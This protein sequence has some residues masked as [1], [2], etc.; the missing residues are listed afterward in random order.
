MARVASVVATL[1]TLS[2][3]PL[4]RS[5]QQICKRK[6]LNNT[7]Y[8]LNSIGCTLIELELSLFGDCQELPEDLCKSCLLPFKHDNYNIYFAVNLGLDDFIVIEFGI[9]TL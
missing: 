4:F 2:T 9:T 6:E 7:R 5:L 1:A 3:K 8:F